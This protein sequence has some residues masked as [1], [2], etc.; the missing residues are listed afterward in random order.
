MGPRIKTLEG[1]TIRTYQ[2]QFC[3]SRHACSLG[4]RESGIVGW[5]LAHAEFLFFSVFSRRSLLPSS[6]HP[7]FIIF[8]VPRLLFYIQC[9]SRVNLCLKNLGVLCGSAVNFFSQ[10]SNLRFVFSH[11]IFRQPQDDLF[12]SIS[13]PIYSAGSSAKYY[14]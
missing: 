10:I 7:Y 8:C 5:A 14:K 1:V 6:L 12:P 11:T 2:I 4:N 13:P 9:Q 3:H